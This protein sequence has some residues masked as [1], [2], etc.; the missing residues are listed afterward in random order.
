MELS[1]PA[2][3][4][5]DFRIRRATVGDAALLARAASNLFAQTFAAQNRPEDLRAYL[6]TAF[7]ED[8]QSRELADPNGLLWVAE[9]REAAIGYAHVKLGS[10]PPSLP[11]ERPA[12]LVRIYADRGWHGKGVGARLL[13]TCV[14]AALDWGAS[15]IWLGVWKENPRGIAFYQKNGFQIAGEQTFLLGSDPQHD[16]IM[17][18]DLDQRTAGSS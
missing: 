11:I 10:A 12:E 1:S 3:H 18:R 17:V 5:T 13:E 4:V 8:Q 2:S 6:S 14:G 9:D 16:W 7:G 15:A